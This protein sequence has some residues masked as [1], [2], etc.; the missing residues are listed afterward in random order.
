MMNKINKNILLCIVFVSLTILVISNVSAGLTFQRGSTI[1]FKLPCYNNGSYCS[2]TA[3]CYFTLAY[4]NSTILVD[5]QTMTNGGAY[6]S[7]TIPD[8]SVVGTYAGSVVCLDSGYTGYSTF[9]IDITPEGMSDNQ[10][11]YV[12]A[13]LVMGF[14][15]VYMFVYKKNR[16]VGSILIFGMGIAVT[17]ISTTTIMRVVGGVIFIS[18]LITLIYDTIYRFTEK[19]NRV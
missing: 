9:E 1:N 4:P 3:E 8:S 11:W 18:A 16:F 10:M 7:Y 2:A 17:Y 13:G 5:N 6:H 19:P 15:F 14:V 12:L